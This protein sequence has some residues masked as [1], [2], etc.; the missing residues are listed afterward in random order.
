M[1]PAYLGWGNEE[2]DSAGV[3]LYATD[4]G[5]SPRWDMRYRGGRVVEYAL[6]EQFGQAE[7]DRFLIVRI[8]DRFTPD[9]AMER[10]EGAVLEALGG[11][12]NDS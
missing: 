9:E 6:V 7:G 1:I 10:V 8:G 5:Q 11:P 3:R 2:R 12:S 4:R